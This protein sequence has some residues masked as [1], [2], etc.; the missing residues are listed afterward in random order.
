MGRAPGSQRSHSA[1]GSSGLCRLWLTGSFLV[2]RNFCLS[3]PKLFTSANLSPQKTKSE[4]NQVSEVFPVT[5]ATGFEFLLH[6]RS[7][8]GLAP[9]PDTED[10]LLPSPLVAIGMMMT[11]A[12]TG[13]AGRQSLP[14][15][16]RRAE[17]PWLSPRQQRLAPP[18]R[19]LH[20]PLRGQPAASPSVSF[21]LLTLRNPHSFFN[22]FT[23]KRSLSPTFLMS[24]AILCLVPSV[25]HL[26]IQNPSVYTQEVRQPTDRQNRAGESC[27]FTYFIIFNTFYFANSS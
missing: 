14:S 15:S 1:A 24:V 27:L 13:T 10:T 5:P 22:S 7:C 12:L 9:T 18:P 26:G 25:C 21:K 20:C 3:H 4:R 8:P 6:K 16:S 23:L 17:A 19:R 2:R 11:S